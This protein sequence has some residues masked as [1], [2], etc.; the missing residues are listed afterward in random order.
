VPLPAERVQLLLAHSGTAHALAR[1]A[2]AERRAECARALEGARRAGCVAPRAA[3]RDLAAA[4]LGAL[5]AVL[6]PTAFRR[7]RHVVTENARVDAVCAALE[8]G[9]LTAVGAA[10]RAGMQSLRCDFEVSTPELDALCRIG[11]AQPGVRGSRLTGAGFGGCSLHWVA[12]EA[13]AEAARAIADGFERE[14]GR[15]PPVWQVAP[16]AGACALVP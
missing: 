13:A 9:D 10:L 8:A 7:A 14:F 2:Y 1:G 12:P 15:R 4:D 5:E 16:A 11:D 3:L 6:D